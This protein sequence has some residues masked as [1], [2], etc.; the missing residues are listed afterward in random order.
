MIPLLAA[1]IEVA[2]DDAVIFGVVLVPLVGPL[3]FV[4]TGDA[5]MEAET[6]LRP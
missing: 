2:E 5:S 3:L 6:L 1:P 4:G